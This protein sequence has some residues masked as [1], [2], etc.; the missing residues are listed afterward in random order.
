MSNVRVILANASPYEPNVE[1][2]EF[3]RTPDIMRDCIRRCTIDAPE[4]ELENERITKRGLEYRGF[5]NVVRIDGKLYPQGYANE[6]RDPE[7]TAEAVL[8]A[9]KAWRES[10]LKRA[11]N[12]FASDNWQTGQT[13]R[14]RPTLREV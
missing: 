14:E 12:C 2:P 7:S 6:D 8:E 5:E 9:A 11:E 3:K 1:F 13:G 10:E 4:C